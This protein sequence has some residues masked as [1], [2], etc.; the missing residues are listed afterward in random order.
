MAD[1]IALIV[2]SLFSTSNQKEWKKRK[3]EG[4][5][6]FLNKDFIVTWK[7]FATWDSGEGTVDC[8]YQAKIIL[9]PTES[10]KKH[11]KLSLMLKKNSFLTKKEIHDY[12]DES[13]TKC[14]DDDFEDYCTYD[15]SQPY[16][17]DY[18]ENLSDEVEEWCQENGFKLIS[19]EGDGY[20]DDYEPKY[21]RS[22]Y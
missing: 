11:E 16:V 8:Y 12:F 14:L 7:G 3:Q 5:K 4:L 21:R 2:F 15:D 1:N 19:V 9:K 18:S 10:I 22:W 20:S 6:Q 17:E 13:L